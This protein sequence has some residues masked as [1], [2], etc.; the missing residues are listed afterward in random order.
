MEANELRMIISQIIDQIEMLVPVYVANEEDRLKAN[1]NV[2]VCIVDASGDV[3]GKI[4]GSDKIRGR[5]AFRVA[6]IK[7]SQVW[8]TG[9]RTGEFE[10]KVFTKEIDE[11]VFGIKRPDY[12]GWEGG[13]PVELPGGTVAIGFSGFT[14]ATDIEIVLRAIE[15]CMLPVTVSHHKHN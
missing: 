6:W 3:H 7:A 4:F 9:M 8:I 14:S 11:T 12:V 10:K 15:E 1:G 5:E 13:Q 2:A